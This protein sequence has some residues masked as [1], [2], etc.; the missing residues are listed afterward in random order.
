MEITALLLAAGEG[1][2]LRPL[3]LDWPKC[4]MPIKGRPLLEY[5]ISLLDQLNVRSILV[6]THHKKRVM[7][8][9]LNRNRFHGLVSYTYEPKFLGTGG[10]LLAN[11][12]FFQDKTTLFIH[13]DNWCHCD[14]QA[15]I[16]FHSYNRPAGTI[17]TMMT[18]STPTPSS[19]GIVE[20]DNDGI[21]QK[22]HE[23]VKNPPGNLANAAIYLLEPEVLDIVQNLPDVSD[24]DI[25]VIPSL[26]GKIATW[27]NTNIHRDIGT[28]ESLLEAQNDSVPTLDSSNPD[29]W[30]RNFE[31]N[32]IHKSLKV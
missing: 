14:F 30:Q 19:C 9:F 1:T 24:F 6:N 18:F 28:L 4:L 8:E 16:D 26:L 7:E 3:T 25:D 11:K 23:K 21:V 29:E 13:A 27:E 2:R 15:F 32:S 22:F 5:W 31:K 10:T 12:D 20:L 17:M